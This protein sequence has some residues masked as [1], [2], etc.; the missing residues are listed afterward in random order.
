[1]GVRWVT[2]L[3]A[4]DMQCRPGEEVEI[5]GVYTHNFDASLN[6]RQGF[7]VFATVIEANFVQKRHNAMA[8]Y[9]LTE[10]DKEK[11]AEL[12]RDPNIAER[13]GVYRA[14][15][16]RVHAPRWSQLP[17]AWVYRS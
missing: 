8:A 16:T 12:S 14:A 1:V 5:T 2:T 4:V 3:L 6:T 17:C 13:V 7:P 15:L 9:S 10:E 11:I